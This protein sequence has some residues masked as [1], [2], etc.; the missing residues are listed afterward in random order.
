MD[1][2]KVN[3]WMI[4]TAVLALVVGFLIGCD[5]PRQQVSAQSPAE[6][7]VLNSPDVN[8]VNVPMVRV[9]GTLYPQN[10][11]H[12][13]AE[14][15]DLDDG[16]FTPWTVPSGFTF[17]LTE[18][19]SSRGV[20]CQSPSLPR[21]PNGGIDVLKVDPSGVVVPVFS[22]DQP[23]F[24]LRVPI[25]FSEEEEVYVDGHWISSGGPWGSVY[26]ISGFLEPNN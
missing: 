15:C 26:T 17:Y 9:V 16:P 2:N 3:S 21:V 24:S 5:S 8:V 10:A 12:I 23:S 1:N 4:S 13:R 14:E 7:I 22:V 6:V 19:S 18:I 20:I 25:I 11:I